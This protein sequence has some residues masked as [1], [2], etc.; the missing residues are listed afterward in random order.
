MAKIKG[1]SYGY[2]ARR[3]E[4]RSSRGIKSQELM[5]ETGINWVCLPVINKC[6][7]IHSTRI[8][9][10][11]TLPS[12]RDL[13]AV[14]DR[15]KEHEVKVCLKPMLNSNDNLWRA[16][17][18]ES[19]EKH[20][21]RSATWDEWFKSYTAFIIYYAELAEETGCEMLCLGCELLGTEHRITDWTTLI[22]RV[23]SAFSGK[24][25]YNTNHHEEEGYEWME[26][27]DY[28]G[29]SAYYDVSSNGLSREALINEWSK[30]RDRLN[31]IAEKKDKQYLFMEI[32]CRSAFG[33]ASMP[34]DFEQTGL[35]WSEEEQALFY[36]TCLEVFARDPHFAGIFWWDWCT[37][38]YRTREEAESDVSFNVHLKKAEE[39]LKKWNAEDWDVEL[40]PPVSY[41]CPYKSGFAMKIANG[42]CKSARGCIHNKDGICDLLSK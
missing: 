28:I 24:L 21:D 33:C 14:I 22:H 42:E 4:Y 12:D 9:G 41:D 1:M 36:D 35:P 25:V 7:N 26:L 16:Y 40:I 11:Y 32:G 31:V 2:Y 17:I 5:Y 39:V 15:A 38:V 20:N 19:W 18:G 23:R 3:G 29:T 10:D 30:H 8:Y 27:L 6:E 13:I 37:F 34:W